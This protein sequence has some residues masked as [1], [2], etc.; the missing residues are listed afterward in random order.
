[1]I[2]AP[3]YDNRST[4]AP[5]SHHQSLWD[6]WIARILLQIYDERSWLYE[7][8]TDPF[9]TTNSAHHQ[10]SKIEENT[11]SVINSHINKVRSWSSK[12]REWKGTVNNG[13]PPTLHVTWSPSAYALCRHSLLQEVSPE[14]YHR[15]MHLQLISHANDTPTST[16]DLVTISYQ[17]LVKGNEDA[18]YE[19]APER[20]CS[21][22]VISLGTLGSIGAVEA[23]QKLQPPM[24]WDSFG[25]QTLPRKLIMA[26]KLE[27][28]TPTLMLFSLAGTKQRNSTHIS[29][30]WSGVY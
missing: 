3:G 30:I 13:K 9:I 26:K 11:D 12:H 22:S 18:M 20:R 8:L 5:F 7:S 15:A 4:M 16:F 21:R 19:G 10:P 24:W 2:N 27:S 29:N 25:R 6:A 23:R 17:P 14:A 1:M 28:K